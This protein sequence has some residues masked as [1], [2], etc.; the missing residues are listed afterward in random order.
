MSPSEQ[1]LSNAFNQLFGTGDAAGANLGPARAQFAAAA[2]AA[3]RAI[4]NAYLTHTG[5]TNWIT[6]TNFRQWGGNVLK[7]YGVAEFL[8]YGNGASTARY[9]HAFQDGSG[10]ALNAS[11]HPSGYLLRFPAGA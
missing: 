7:R 10:A 6:I 1:A 2:R 8:Q 4:L 3:H 11:D 5:P 9:Y